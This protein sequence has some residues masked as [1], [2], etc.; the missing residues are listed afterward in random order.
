MD[1]QLCTKNIYIKESKNE[2]N[3]VVPKINYK[4][5]GFVEASTQSYLNFYTKKV[6]DDQINLLLYV[7]DLILTS[8]DPKILSHL[9]S[10]LQNK[11]EME[12]SWHFHYFLGL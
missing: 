9:K 1:L 2:I 6:G 3:K 11:Y 4:Y 5:F 8:S 10:I 7:D 12:D